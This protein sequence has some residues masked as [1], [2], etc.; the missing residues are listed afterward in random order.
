[1]ENDRQE[2]A[3]SEPPPA[4]VARQYQK[5]RAA[6][7]DLDP[8]P[9]PVRQ[10]SP[11]VD[12]SQERQARKKIPTV[13]EAIEWMKEQNVR[14]GRF[15]FSH[16]RFPTSDF[17][18]DMSVGWFASLSASDNDVVSAMEQ[19]HA[20]INRV[21]Q[22]AEVL[23]V[24]EPLLESVNVEVSRRILAMSSSPEDTKRL[25]RPLNLRR[26]IDLLQ[27]LEQPIPDPPTD[28][29]VGYV[30]LKPLARHTVQVNLP[31][32]A[33]V[34]EV[35]NLLKGLLQTEKATLFEPAGKTYKEPT[36]WTYRF[37]VGST[38]DF[39]KPAEP[40]S[41]DID[42]RIMISEIIRKRIPRLTSV[43]LEM[44]GAAGDKGETHNG[45]TEQGTD[46]MRQGTRYKTRGN[47]SEVRLSRNRMNRSLDT[48][49]FEESSSKTD[50]APL[51]KSQSG[52]APED[53]L[54]DEDGNP[55]FD[56]GP[57]DWNKVSWKRQNGETGLSDEVLKRDKRRRTAV[58]DQQ[59][60]SKYDLRRRRQT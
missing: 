10:H 47:M 48:D 38:P 1:M 51:S 45:K 29:V 8:I 9:R 59:Q 24:N 25:G 16:G 31:L 43:L 28:S 15:G 44:E 20:D 41:S 60:T 12:R 19:M 2:A 56:E 42:Y 46:G 53:N 36:F 21:K 7:P 40:L 5:P 22:R 37:V 52:Y 3:G 39:T 11:A 27:A 30:S 57:I 32:D 58:P 17:F 34:A 50:P 33:S 54:F 6:S 4:K 49:R 23:G 55:Y 26:K 35:Y 13:D 14:L 18:K